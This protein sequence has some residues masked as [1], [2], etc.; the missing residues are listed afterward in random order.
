MSER[1]TRGWLCA[2]AIIMLATSLTIL[3][4]GISGVTNP[5]LKYNSMHIY[6][7][8]MCTLAFLFVVAGGIIGIIG[9]KRHSSK[10]I[11]I[12]FWFLLFTCL[13][14]FGVASNMYGLYEVYVSRDGEVDC[15]TGA[16]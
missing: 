6:V 2:T 7:I 3:S 11:H 4:A 12:M 13:W 1:T 16:F 14:T 8:V 15:N 10:C 9:I 5:F